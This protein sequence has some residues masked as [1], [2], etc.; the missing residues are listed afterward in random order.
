VFVEIDGRGAWE[1]ARVT[2][3]ESRRFC[4]LGA[5]VAV[6]VLAF[7]V[8]LVT[9]PVGHGTRVLD[10]LGQVGAALLAGLAARYR[11]QR[12]ADRIRNFW[13]WLAAAAFVWAGGQLLW[14]AYELI[15]HKAPFPSF[16]DVGFFLAVPAIACAIVSL[17]PHDLRPVVQARIA[18]DSVIVASSMLFVG[19]FVLRD[20][21]YA[22]SH[23][24]SALQQVVGVAFPMGDVAI[25]ALVIIAASH[26]ATRRVPFGT[27]GVALV[28][29]A[30]SDGT[31]AYF[32]GQQHHASGNLID[33][34]WVLGYLLLALAAFSPAA[35][36]ESGPEEAD[37][38]GA[39]WRGW[40][41]YPAV[42]LCG[43]F[44]LVH[45]IEGIALRGLLLWTA[46]VLFLAITVRQLVVLRENHSLTR[47]LEDTVERRTAELRSSEE[48]LQT[49][50]QHVSDVVSVV[51]RSGE[52]L[53][54]SSSVRE[55]LG[56][57]PD[58][59][60]DVNILS[61]VHPDEVAL[62]ETFLVDMATATKPTAHLE[63]R[64]RHRSG[65]WRYTE[66]AGADLTEDPVLQ[67]IVLTTRDVTQR[68]QL[69]EQLTDQAFHDSLTGLPNRALF[70]D[71]LD[72]AV[73]RATRIG[74]P[75]AVLFIDLDDFKAVNDTLGH[76]EGD[77]L[78]RH[79]AS[80]L[81][82]CVRLSDTVA[83][84]GGDEFAVLM[85][86]ASV[87][88][89]LEAADRIQHRLNR[90]VMVQGSE[91]VVSASVGVAATDELVGESTE[92][93]RNA[94][95][96]MYSAKTDGKARYK[97]F[98]SSMHSRVVERTA[99]L[100]DLRHALERREMDVCFQPIVELASLEACGFEALVRWHHPE[101]G[102]IDPIEF[103]NLAEQTGL[104]VAIG[105]YVLE[106]SCRQLVEWDNM[107]ISGEA[108]TVSVN[109]S[110][111]QLIAPDLVATVERVLRDTGVEPSRLTLELTE[112]MLLDD[113]DTSTEQLQALKRLGVRLAIDDFGT[114]YSS[115]SYLRQLPVDFLK[116]DRSF[117]DGLDAELAGA[118][119]VRA[120]IDLGQRL[121][122]T[123][124]AEGIETPEQ[125]GF[126]TGA[127]CRLAQGYYFCRPLAVPQ[128]HDYLRSKSRQ[129]HAVA[130][131]A[132]AHA[133]VQ[134]MPAAS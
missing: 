126:L 30:V 51:N 13:G 33:T 42:L 77:E 130:S 101:R 86:D 4:A 134:D 46:I 2:W 61:F 49:V 118:D 109:V 81:A 1:R 76:R 104:I 70:G 54:V 74:N 69:E 34:G 8:M 102:T 10:D 132:V 11:S 125:A 39:S 103:I 96:A 105:E 84:L 108:L 58:E 100:S 114:G 23:G 20:R 99:L 60:S 73:S 14:S 106:E 5:L 82:M 71:R 68:R 41:P 72:H 43:T 95:I 120:I 80:E 129:L 115:L 27:I 6:V 16:A 53:S 28:A 85:E 89:A 67:G 12:A 66:T 17:V 119:L 116:I 94:D 111:R 21:L 40:L 78:L 59:L 98:E 25:L 97:L 79:V 107:G 128:V 7:F 121:Q 50:I 131:A 36:S 3:A 75:L 122:L 124:I 92:L 24:R 22:G 18:V 47:G 35:E 87:A 31:Y 62:L 29:I 26:F 45:A 38:D 123:T 117:I 63:A 83:R 56:Y 110:G 88:E 15:G 64:M 48:R 90:P 55:V 57:R 112:S 127:G 32:M 113:I 9:G 52:I 37:D 133:A 91:I 19:W 65:T 93:M 44:I